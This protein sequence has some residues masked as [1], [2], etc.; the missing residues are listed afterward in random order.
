MLVLSRKP[1]QEIL[2]GDNIKL[3]IL[4]V[5]G[6]TVRIGIEAPQEVKVIRGEL[7]VQPARRTELTVTFRPDQEVQSMASPA[8]IL[9]FET[10]DAGSREPAG[11]DRATLK[12]PSSAPSLPAAGASAIS[13]KVS[14]FTA[15][16]ATPA[17]TPSAGAATGESS[18]PGSAAKEI[19]DSDGGIVRSRGPQ[20][21]LVLTTNRIQDVLARMARNTQ[22]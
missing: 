20:K 21:P 6:N 3:T 15:A 12:N 18:A 1:N 9:P 16:G 22:E 7:P 5:K 10:R 11:R 2:I 13:S 14:G 19:A 17:G 4:R 8:R